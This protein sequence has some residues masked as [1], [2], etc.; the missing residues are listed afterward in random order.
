V[1]HLFR[2]IA[3]FLVALVLY[4]ATAS[5]DESMRPIWL[6]ALFI[7]VVGTIALEGVRQLVHCFSDGGR[8]SA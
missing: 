7:S 1:N 2:A 8:T 3:C 4:V 6:D 5:G